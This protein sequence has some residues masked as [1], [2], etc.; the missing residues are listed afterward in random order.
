MTS[1][2]QRYALAARILHWIMAVG[3]IFMWG[4]GYAMTSLVE[5]DSPLEE[6]LFGLH[7]STGVTLLFLLI[8]RILVRFTAVVPPL[9]A[10]LSSAERI[11]S[12]LGHLGLYLAPAVVIAIGWAESDFGGHGVTWFGVSMPKIFPTMEELNGIN[13]ESTLADLH[14]WIAYAMLGLAVIHVAAVAKHRWI[15]KHDVLHRM[16]FGGK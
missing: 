13:L 7:I 9:P 11:G 14:M 12:Q 10:G 2:Q 3:F 8:V 15:D 6:L 5:D 1:E 16:T 4:C